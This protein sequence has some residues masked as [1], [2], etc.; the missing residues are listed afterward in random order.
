M[1]HQ[2]VPLQVV[3]DNATRWN[4]RKRMLSRLLFLRP[5]IDRLF[6][7]LKSEWMT[8]R[9][10]RGNK[11]PSPP[12]LEFRLSEGDWEVCAYFEEVLTPFETA[13]SLLEGMPAGKDNQIKG[14]RSGAFWRYFLA[15]EY[16]YKKIESHQ[17]EASNGDRLNSL[18]I[19]R[20]ESETLKT[21]VI[22][23]LGRCHGKLSKYYDLMKSVTYVA[24]IAL[25][26]CYGFRAMEKGW[27]EVEWGPGWIQKYNTDLQALWTKDYKQR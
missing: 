14:M 22:D 9:R 21:L 18:A 27:S 5:Y 20:D 15:F 2:R 26:P 10:K 3:L 8:A 11:E 16:L 23:A 12:I 25:H 24:A 4:S 17:S 6:T 7:Y 1:C 13:T 19:T